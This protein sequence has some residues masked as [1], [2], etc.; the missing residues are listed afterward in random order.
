MVA[1]CLR[2]NHLLVITFPARCM[3]LDLDL[4]VLDVLAPLPSTVP[5]R[6]SWMAGWPPHDSPGS[7]VPSVTAVQLPCAVHDHSPVSK[8]HIVDAALGL[9]QYL[10]L[11]GPPRPHFLLLLQLS[12]PATPAT[13]SA[14]RS[15]QTSTH[16]GQ[17]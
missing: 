6:A 16:F 15:V 10:C 3:T 2:G 13:P 12:P 7:A 9:V 17:G 4:L 1:R 14:L 5:S 8:F 11:W